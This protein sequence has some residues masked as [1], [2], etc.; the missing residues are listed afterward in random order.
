MRIELLCDYCRRSE[1]RDL[2]MLTL[3][4]VK[5]LKDSCTKVIC[6]DCVSNI[7]SVLDDI[8]DRRDINDTLR[9]IESDNPED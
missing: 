5:D 3:T 8:L 7:S 1:Q 4:N 2:F 6:S 9:E